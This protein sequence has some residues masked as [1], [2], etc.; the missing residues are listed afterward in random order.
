VPGGARCRCPLL[1]VPAWRKIS[2]ESFASEE[3][4]W[5]NWISPP[6][7][8]WRASGL[9]WGYWGTPVP[10]IP[11]AAERGHACAGGNQSP[12]P[13]RFGAWRGVAAGLAPGRTEALWF[14]GIPLRWAGGV[15][16]AAASPGVALKSPQVRKDS[17]FCEL[18]L[19]K[20]R[21]AKL[22]I[23]IF[24]FP[25]HPSH[26]VVSCHGVRW[27]GGPQGGCRD[28]TSRWQTHRGG[29]LY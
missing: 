17:N 21:V 16:R 10:G 23:Y 9:G 13:Q 11:G 14:P 8:A 15:R 12:N 26:L 27:P 29:E 24:F 5:C 2:W 22:V 1:R 3:F 7:C 19:Q 4:P 20:E 28:R 18:P 25:P 6:T